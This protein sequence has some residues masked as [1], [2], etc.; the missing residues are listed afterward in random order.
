L[1][2]DRATRELQHAAAPATSAGMKI[3]ALR[4]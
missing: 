4:A 2:R 1:C 3:R